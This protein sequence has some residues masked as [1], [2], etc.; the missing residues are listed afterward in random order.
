MPDD[1]TVPVFAPKDYKET[2]K[3]GKFWNAFCWFPYSHVVSTSQKRTVTSEF[4]ECDLFLSA[5]LSFLN[6]IPR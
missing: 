1:S 4:A 3:V 5:R 2:F 6:L